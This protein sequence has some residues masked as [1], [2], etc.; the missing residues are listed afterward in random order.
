V[1]VVKQIMMRARKTIKRFFF[2]LPFQL[3]LRDNSN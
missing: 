2:I 1:K 3:L